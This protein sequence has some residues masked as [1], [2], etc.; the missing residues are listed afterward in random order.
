MDDLTVWLDDRPGA[1]AELGEVLGAAGISIE[2]GGVFACQGQAI[3]HFLVADGN[4]ASQALATAGFTATPRLVLVR[5]LHQDQPG[6]LGAIARRIADAGIN[7]EVMYSDHD[8]HL[9]LV[10]DDEPNAA[11][12]TTQWAPQTTTA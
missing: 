5:Q 8:H 12:A 3:A 11:A 1:L 6:Q 2:G 7:I 9:V 10:V 4:H